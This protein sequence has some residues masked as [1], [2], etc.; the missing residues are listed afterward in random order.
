VRDGFVEQEA[1]RLGTAAEKRG[2]TPVV[3]ISDRHGNAGEQKENVPGRHAAGLFLAPVFSLYRYGATQ[4]R[5]GGSYDFPLWDSWRLGFP[6]AYTFMG[7]FSSVQVGVRATLDLRTWHRFSVYQRVGAFF[8][9][10]SGNGR[11][12]V[13]GSVDLGVG[14][15]YR[16]S[17]RIWLGLEPVSVEAMVVA[18]GG[19]PWNLRGQTRMEVRGEW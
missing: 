5:L 9:R 18:T 12:F 15:R 19:V 2:T 10:Y 16:L 8:E 7:G 11:S 3:A 13:A 1:I 17:K 14:A 6:V 4:F